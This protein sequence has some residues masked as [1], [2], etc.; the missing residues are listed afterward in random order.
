MDEFRGY[1]TPDKDWTVVNRYRRL[2][3]DGH[4]NPTLCPD[5]EKPLTTGRDENE[6]FILVCLF[7]NYVFRPGL[8]WWSNI[9]S[10]VKEFYLE[11]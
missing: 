5:C 7:D 6:N 1:K 8:G 3:Q 9:R 4:A 2:V 10:I 11:E